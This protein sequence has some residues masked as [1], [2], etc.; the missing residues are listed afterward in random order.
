MRNSPSRKLLQAI[1]VTAELT[2]TELSEVAARIMAE[3]LS[4]Y[5]EAQVLDALVRCRKE[6][7]GRIAVADVIQ[8][9]DDGRP[10][11][12]EAWSICSKSLNDEG[13]TIVWTEEMQQAFGIALPLADDLVAARMAFKEAYAGAMQIARDS[14]K[15]VR[16]SPSLGWRAADRTG[17]LVEA[18]ERGRLPIDIAQ[19]FLPPNHGL[20][21]EYLLS[22]ARG[23]A[24]LLSQS[25]DA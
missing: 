10:G 5:P 8:R 3:D 19:Q 18:I 1:A 15:R 25:E 7:R 23:S 16:W 14:G 21:P 20:T 6:L 9:L 4:A 22:M 17:P 12:E 11:V 24:K 2:G 13:A